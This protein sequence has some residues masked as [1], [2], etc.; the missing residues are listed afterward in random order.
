MKSSFC[1]NEMFFSDIVNLSQQNRTKT[2]RSLKNE[3]LF[4]NYIKLSENFSKG[5][6]KSYG[7]KNME[8]MALK[9]LYLFELSFVK[10]E[11]IKRN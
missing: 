1:Y 9:T 2:L 7:A 4:H 3:N 8:H 10:A 6:K 5:R 11:S